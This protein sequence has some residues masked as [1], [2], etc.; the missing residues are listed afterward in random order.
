MFATVRYICTENGRLSLSP[1]RPHPHKCVEKSCYIFVKQ[2]RC[3]IAQKKL[4]L[5]YVYR[6]LECIQDC[7]SFLSAVLGFMLLLLLFYIGLLSIVYR[8]RN[9][10]LFPGD[11]F[12]NYVIP[13]VST[14]DTCKTTREFSYSFLNPKSHKYVQFSLRSVFTSRYRPRSRL[15]QFNFI[16]PRG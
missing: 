3:K 12:T 5:W 6:I 7:A 15:D 13:I 2:T 1:S 4:G 11:I 8:N 16:Q 14:T 9:C 10:A